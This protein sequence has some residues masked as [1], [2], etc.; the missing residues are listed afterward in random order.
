MKNEERAA[1]MR[2]IED[3]ERQV[4]E[5]QARPLQPIQNHYH[6]HYD[7]PDHT[8]G[9]WWVTQPHYFPYSVSP[10]VTGGTLPV[11]GFTLQNTAAQPM[12]TYAP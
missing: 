9:P 7:K 10:T 4:R 12:A 6:Y 1:L 8:Y 3:L 2:R 5:L 11:T